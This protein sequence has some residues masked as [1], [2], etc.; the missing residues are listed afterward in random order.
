MAEGLDLCLAMSSVTV[1]IGNRFSKSGGH[2][3]LKALIKKPKV[4]TRLAKG[5]DKKQVGRQ[6]SLA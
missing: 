5:I 2:R 4:M 3:N 6:A 1:A